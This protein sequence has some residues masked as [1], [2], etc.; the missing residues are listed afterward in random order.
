MPTLL[1]LDSSPRRDS[2]SRR[3]SAEFADAW[4]K[5]HPDG[6]Y[7]HRDLAAEPV[8]HVDHAQIEVMH[9]LETEGTRDLAAARDAAKTAEEKESWA[10]TWPLVE[11]LLAADVILLGVPMYNFSVP[12]TFKAWFDR[13][14]IAPLI[15]DPATGEGPL[16]GKRVVVASAR[17]GAYGPGTPREDCDH[18]EPYLKAALGMVGL[19]ADL[20]F[21]HAEFTK[22]EHV[23]RLAGFKDTAAAS[24]RTALDGARAHGEA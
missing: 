16:S 24:Y 6:T 2:V 9:R 11:E 13:V 12:S 14:L 17:G 22:S 8:P 20:T 5:A 15:A 3:L 21:L 19:A 10:I 23:P 7:V 18:Q 4:R 1:H